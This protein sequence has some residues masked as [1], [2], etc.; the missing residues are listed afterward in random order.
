MTEHRVALVSVVDGHIHLTTTAGA[1]I[2][3][4][5]DEAFNLTKALYQAAKTARTDSN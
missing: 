1:I 2:V 5:T 3:L 4:T